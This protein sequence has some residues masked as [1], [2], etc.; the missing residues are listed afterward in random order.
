MSILVTGSSSYIGK[1]LINYF[2]SN[3]IDYIG[4]DLL[5]KE[6]SENL[7]PSDQSVGTARARH[8]THLNNMLE[9]LYLSK[10]YNDNHHLELVAE[11]LRIVHQNML[12]IKGGDVNEDVLDKIF[13]EFCIGK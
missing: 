10:E 4:I 12:Q 11:E 2:E 1:N 7:V 13:S 9:H 5:T 8:L 3:N 6:I